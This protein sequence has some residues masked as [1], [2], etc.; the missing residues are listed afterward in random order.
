MSA[1]HRHKPEERAADAFMA[2]AAKPDEPDHLARLAFASQL[3]TLALP[4]SIVLKMHRGRMLTDEER[5]LLRNLPIPV[6][7]ALFSAGDGHAAQGDGEVCVTA[8]ETNLTGV[9][10]FTVRKD[11][12]LRWPRAARARR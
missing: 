4:E 12:K 2:G 6:D 9:F 3:G 5:R 8:I 7:G 1:G 10:R 11:L